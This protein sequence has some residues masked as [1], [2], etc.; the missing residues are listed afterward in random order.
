MATIA[1]NRADP[2]QGAIV[3]PRRVTY[4]ARLGALALS[5]DQLSIPYDQDSPE[6]TGWRKV[7]GKLEP[8][9][10]VEGSLAVP[11][12]Q[13]EAI[14]LERSLKADPDGYLIVVGQH[15]RD[16]W[17]SAVMFVGVL[18]VMALN[19]WALVAV[20]RRRRAEQTS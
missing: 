12:A 14:R 7:G 6:D 13:V 9:A 16:S 20:L 17:P 10:P 15:P 11:R 2:K 18:G 8:V 19:V 4:L 5:K 3:L 1:K